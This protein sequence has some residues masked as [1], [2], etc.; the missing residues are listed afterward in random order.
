[1]TYSIRPIT[2]EDEETLWLMLFYAAHVNEEAGKTLADARANSGL[3]KYVADWGR[4]GDLGFLAIDAKSGKALGAVWAR[5]F[6]GD[7]KAYSATDDSTPELAIAV[8]PEV[9]G[10]G[11]GTTL[12]R[13]FLDVARHEFSAIALN[14]RADNPA[15]R[16]YQRLGFEVVS[17]M[18]NRVGTLS[19]DMRLAF[20]E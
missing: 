5:L 15:L 19:Y 7:D 13:H 3:A 10:Q 6:V 9:I 14:V 20:S 2:P 11:I 8:L 12:M 18:T 1:M 16:L 17:E 4:I